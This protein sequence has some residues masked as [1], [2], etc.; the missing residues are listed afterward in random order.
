MNR[1]LLRFTLLVL[2]VVLAIV[3]RAPRAEAFCLLTCTT[4]GSYVLFASGCCG[5]KAGDAFQ[6]YARWL[7]TN[8]CAHPTTPRQLVCSTDPCE[9]I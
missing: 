8:G 4:E 1:T 6:Q 5:G 9:P 7:C 2:A 3:S